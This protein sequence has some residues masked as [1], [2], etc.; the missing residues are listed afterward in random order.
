LNDLKDALSKPR[1]SEAASYEELQRFVHGA[2][3]LYR[4]LDEVEDANK[5]LGKNKIKRALPVVLKYTA[6][7]AAK[8]KTTRKD[9]PQAVLTFLNGKPHPGWSDL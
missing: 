5:A 2:D 1:F 6:M 9:L 8:L 7:A 3:S 4:I